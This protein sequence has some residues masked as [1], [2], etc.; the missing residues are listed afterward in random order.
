V[1]DLDSTTRDFLLRKASEAVPLI[2]DYYATDERTK[3]HGALLVVH[4]S[5][6]IAVCQGDVVQVQQHPSVGVRVTV[7]ST[8]DSIAEALMRAWAATPEVSDYPLDAGG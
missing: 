4:P 8:V 7:N 5:G 3:H 1:F 6:T 2:A